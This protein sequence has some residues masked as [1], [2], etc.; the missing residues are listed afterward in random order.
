M[1]VVKKVLALLAIGLLCN[2]LVACLKVEE[3]LG[4]IETDEVIDESEQE[5][6]PLISEESE[7]TVVVENDKLKIFEPQKNE[8]IEKEFDVIGA[9]LDGERIVYYEVEDGH[10]IVSEGTIIIPEQEKDAKWYDFIIPIELNEDI[11]GAYRLVIYVKDQDNELN[12]HTVILPID[13]E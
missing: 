10:F 9:V 6:L 13:V 5:D 12:L 2:G 1:S 7:R 4:T 3:E 11:H 8:R